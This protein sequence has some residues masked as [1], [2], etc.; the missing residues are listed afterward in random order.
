MP[1][2]AALD[3]HNAR[4]AG[5][6]TRHANRVHRRFRSRVGESP[7]R[8]TE[9]LDQHLGDERVVLTRAHEQSSARQLFSDQTAQRWMGVTGEQ[10]P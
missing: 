7:L 1:V 8:E 3:L 2:I 10:A 5:D 4:P 9:P 6:A